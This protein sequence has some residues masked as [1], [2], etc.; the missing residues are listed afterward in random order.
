M[1]IFRSGIVQAI[2]VRCVKPIQHGGYKFEVGERYELKL[3]MGP[4]FVVKSS[5]G[6]EVVVPKEAFEL[7]EDKKT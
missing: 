4:L 2:L 3:D 7:T 5:T 6:A 1:S